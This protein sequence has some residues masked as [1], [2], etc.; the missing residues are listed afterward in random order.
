MGSHPDATICYGIAFNEDYEFPW[1]EGDLESFEE[2]WL[3][4][5]GYVNPHPFP[6]TPDGQRK[7]G[8]TREDAMVYHGHKRTWLKENPPPVRLVTGYSSDYPFYVL[9]VPGT[10]DTAHEGGPLPID[11]NLMVVTTEE[12][13]ALIGFCATYVDPEADKWISGWLLTAYYG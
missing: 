1:E 4:E 7:S 11:P 9:A 3:K 8:I 13:L 2:W 10:V 6:Y 5:Q 12:R